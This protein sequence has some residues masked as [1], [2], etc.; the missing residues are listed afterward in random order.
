MSDRRKWFAEHPGMRA[1]T[2]ALMPCAVLVMNAETMLVQRHA[3]Q[4]G[5]GVA[6][7]AI[8]TGL[9]CALCFAVGYY[10]LWRQVLAGPES[11]PRWRRRTVITLWAAVGPAINVMLLQ[12]VLA[13][14][15]VGRG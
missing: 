10:P 8:V 3:Y 9:V 13:P 1:S 14:P 5:P 15:H 6:T 11:G 4:T 2:A 12:T 7:W